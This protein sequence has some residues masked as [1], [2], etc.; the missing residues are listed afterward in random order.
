[1]AGTMPN[2]HRIGVQ[3]GIG[4]FDA[5]RGHVGRRTELCD[6]PAK[7]LQVAVGGIDMRLRVLLPKVVTD[8]A[9]LAVETCCPRMGLHTAKP[10]F[11]RRLD[12]ASQW[13]EPACQR[14]TGV[15]RA[16]PCSEEY[17]SACLRIA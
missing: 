5:G 9:T 1:N 15:S 8:G 4:G 14:P 10:L 2:D 6:G 7:H 11:A 17:A 16:T 13:V 3:E 12:P